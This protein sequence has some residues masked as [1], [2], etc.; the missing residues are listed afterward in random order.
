MLYNYYKLGV[1]DLMF[2]KLILCLL[3]AVNLS[4]QDNREAV[5]KSCANEKTR[6]DVVLG[7]F[8]QATKE[9]G[10]TPIAVLKILS[11]EKIVPKGGVVLSLGSGKNF[12]E[13]IL[14]ILNRKDIAVVVIEKADQGLELFA[15]YGSLS[16]GDIIRRP[17]DVIPVFAEGAWKVIKKNNPELISSG[18]IKT[19]EAF[20]AAIKKQIVFYS[21][22]NYSEGLRDVK[23]DLIISRLPWRY[24][25]YGDLRKNG[26]AWVVT[27]RNLSK[28]PLKDPF[29][30]KTNGYAVVKMPENAV[31]NLFPSNFLGSNMQKRF[32]AFNE[33]DAKPYLFFPQNNS[34]G[35]YSD[36]Y[37]S[38]FPAVKVVQGEYLSYGS[39]FKE[40]DGSIKLPDMPYGGKMLYVISETDEGIKVAYS[41]EIPNLDVDL[42][43]PKAEILVTHRSLYKMLRSVGNVKGFLCSGEIIFMPNGEIS[44]FT[45]R[46]NTFKSGKENLDFAFNFFKEHGVNL[47]DRVVLA[48]Y[49]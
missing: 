39:I 42:D 31:N 45:N 33:Y 44:L 21:A 10:E 41:N 40:S 7:V 35:K 43:D 30:L 8:E 23:A 3:L 6:Q 22:D 11:D 15:G 32:L 38:R 9:F 20:V 24:E 37:V 4:A 16:Y 5:A 27:E 29:A 28:G 48:D 12:Y 2:N 36:L 25:L 13:W 1:G 49:S 17:D 18:R 14:P 47:S 46:S 19:E 34:D 26:F